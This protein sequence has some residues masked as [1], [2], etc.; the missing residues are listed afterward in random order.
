MNKLLLLLLSATVAVAV[1]AGITHT[2]IQKNNISP[3]ATAAKLAKETHA[4]GAVGSWT[5]PWL[6]QAG[7]SC[8]EVGS[9]NHVGL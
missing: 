7:I 6:G 4:T 8:L 9:R 5:I 2:A 1:T 3:K